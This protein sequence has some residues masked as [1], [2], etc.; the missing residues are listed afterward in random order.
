MAKHK[1]LVFEVKKSDLS[2][3]NKLLKVFLGILNDHKKIASILQNEHFDCYEKMRSLKFLTLDTTKKM[4]VLRSKMH[5]VSGRFREIFQS[6]RQAAQKG[7]KMERSGL[8]ETRIKPIQKQRAPE[9]PQSNENAENNEFLEMDKALGL[10]PKTEKE[11]SEQMTQEEILSKMKEEQRVIGQND[12]M[13]S[14]LLGEKLKMNRMGNSKKNVRREQTSRRPSQPRIPN[15]TNIM[16][17][18]NPKLNEIKQDS[19]VEL[20]NLIN[21]QMNGAQLAA[22]EPIDQNNV[23]AGLAK[24]QEKNQTKEGVNKGRREVQ[25]RPTSGERDELHSSSLISGY[26]RKTIDNDVRAEN[27]VEIHSEVV[28]KRQNIMEHNMSSSDLRSNS[29]NNFEGL[30]QPQDS[31]NLQNSFEKQKDSNESFVRKEMKSQANMFKNDIKTPKTVLSANKLDSTKEFPY[32]GAYAKTPN[33]VNKTPSLITEPETEKALS[34]AMPFRREKT[35]TEFNQFDV[36]KSDLPKKSETQ[37]AQNDKNTAHTNKPFSM[38]VVTNKNNQK[39]KSFSKMPKPFEQVKYAPKPPEPVAE[40][41]KKQIKA[42]AKKKAED[43]NIF[44]SGFGG[45]FENGFESFDL[46]NFISK[47][48][49]DAQKRLDPKKNLKVKK[50]LPRLRGFPTFEEFLKKGKL[51]MIPGL[52]LPR[53]MADI[54]KSGKT[55][56]QL[57]NELKVFIKQIKAGKIKPKSL[58]SISTLK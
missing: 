18:V 56:Q 6:P 49:N 50:T 4:P 24:A 41:T 29:R 44:E 15:L 45:G 16:E 20:Q 21:L 30:N 38:P 19:H 52:E 46:D 7:E 25:E 34:G 32:S 3:V 13:L 47:P 43:E 10:V 37:K 39:T 5:Q 36:I 28:S 23:L 22:K 33:H 51:P 31:K 26:K 9:A 40:I 2:M 42:K 58:K 53:T 14:S 17:S 11:K 1:E 57:Q 48:Q 12:Q 55:K 35:K 27:P 8:S 54:K